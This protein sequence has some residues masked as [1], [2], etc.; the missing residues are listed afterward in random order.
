M[1]I[2]SN[3]HSIF[4]IS[5]VIPKIPKIFKFPGSQEFSSIFFLY[6]QK[7]FKEKEA[8]PAARVKAQTKVYWLLDEAAASELN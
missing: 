6:S 7:I 2:S 1:R 8:L 4:A 5:R 3:F